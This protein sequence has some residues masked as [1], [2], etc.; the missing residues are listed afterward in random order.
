LDKENAKACLTKIV[1]AVE[2]LG[3][4]KPLIDQGSRDSEENKR[5]SRSLAVVLCDVYDQLLMPLVMEHPELTPPQLKKSLGENLP[6]G[7]GYRP[8][9][10]S[11]PIEAESRHL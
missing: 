4:C 2:L 7:R 1:A 6:S 5:L 11:W 3:E 9:V 8:P 10:E